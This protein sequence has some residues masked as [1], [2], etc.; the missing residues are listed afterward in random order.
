[1]RPLSLSTLALCSILSLPALAEDTGSS[2]ASPPKEA[3]DKK[4]PPPRVQCSIHSKDGSRA[5]QGVNLVVNAGE[6]TRDAVAVDGDVLIRKGAVVEDVVAIHGK[7]TIEEGAKVKGDAVA[8]G[9]EVRLQKKARVEGDVV[10][11]GGSLQMDESASV[12]GDKV[13]FSLSF[14]GDE[15]AQSFLEKALKNSDCQITLRSDDN[16]NDDD[17]D[18]KDDHDE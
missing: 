7:I 1:M 15:L 14:N 17:D 2:Q 18:D 3:K 8:L 4:T 5:V 11:L 12:G 13:S 6:K 9:G 10:A 16:D